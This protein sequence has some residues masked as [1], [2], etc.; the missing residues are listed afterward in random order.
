MALTGLALRLAFALV[1]LDAKTDDRVLLEVKVNGTSMRFG[2]DT[3]AGIETAIWRDTANKIGLKATEPST[4]VK[5]APGNVNMAISEPVTFELMGRTFPDS[6]LAVVDVPFVDWDIQGLVG[7]P[8]LRQNIWVLDLAE[9]KVALVDQVPDETK[10][11]TKYPLNLVEKVLVLQLPGADADHP[12]QLA[13]DTGNSGGVS[14]APARWRDWKAAHPGPPVTYDSFYM[15]GSGF[16]AREI[17]LADKWPLDRLTFANIIVRESNATEIGSGGP[18]YAATLGIAALKQLVI[19]IDGHEGVAY[20]R[21]RAGV[22]PLAAYNRLGAVFMPRD[23]QS[24]DLI[25][26]VAPGSPAA[27]AGLRN[28]DLLETINARDVSHW[29]TQPDFSLSQSFSQPAGTK[30]DLGLRRGQR[31]IH[32]T[33]VLRELFNSPQPTRGPVAAIVEPPSFQFVPPLVGLS[34]KAREL[35]IAIDGLG[36]SNSSLGLQIGDNAAALVSKVEQG[37]L[38]QWLVFLAATD[39]STAEKKAKPKPLSVYTSTGHELLFERSRAGMAI[40]T[41]GPFAEGPDQKPP[42]DVWSGAIVTPQYLALGFETSRRAAIKLFS[43]DINL[44]TGSHPFP[45]EQADTERSRAEAAGFRLEDERAFTGAGLALGEFINIVR[46]TPGLREILFQM[47]DLSWTAFLREPPIGI[48]IM[49]TFEFVPPELWG[50]PSDATG[51][52]FSFK[53]SLDGKPKLLCRMAVTAPRRP[54]QTTAGIVGLAVARVDGTGPHLMVR[55]LA[56][57]EAPEPAAKK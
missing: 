46:H 49:P 43:R 2:F 55:L 10:N 28:G 52:E 13:I 51:C 17:A 53:L 1:P 31:T 36:N 45:K 4:D 12:A 30:L 37:R 42:G 35:G 33:A 29:R 14:L 5:L 8:A 48:E 16:V 34:R 22:P 26:Q 19:V 39:L 38:Q 27:D 21:N 9:N 23:E 20:V 44:S 7:W 24:N 15:P 6:R 40:R 11:W 47:L 56:A 41:V 25:A 50:L 57:H 3:G 54:F 18:H 32:V